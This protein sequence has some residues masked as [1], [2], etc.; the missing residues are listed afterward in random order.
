MM[1]M[2]MTVGNKIKPGDNDDDDDD[3]DDNGSALRL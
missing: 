1:V 3:D 2:M